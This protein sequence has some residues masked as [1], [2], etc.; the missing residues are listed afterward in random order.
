MHH[1][2]CVRSCLFWPQFQI[3]QEVAHRHKPCFDHKSW[4]QA[5]LTSSMKAMHIIAAGNNNVININYRKNASD[6]V[7]RRQWWP[8]HCWRPKSFITMK[9]FHKLTFQRLVQTIQWF[10]HLRTFS[11]CHKTMIYYLDLG[12]KF[13]LLL[14]CRT[15]AS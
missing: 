7:K 14:S 12:L 9:F 1:I 6:N 2:N 8:W 13:S 15:K 3:G 4:P 10:F 5:I 11:W